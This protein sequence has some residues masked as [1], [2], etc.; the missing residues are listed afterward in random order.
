VNSLGFGIVPEQKYMDEVNE[1]K[2]LDSIR[3]IRSLPARPTLFRGRVS[4]LLTQNGSL[5]CQ[6]LLFRIDKPQL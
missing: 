2:H 3:S 6:Q 1:S 5:D 4:A